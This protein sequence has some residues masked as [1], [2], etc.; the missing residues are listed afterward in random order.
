MKNNLKNEIRNF[1]LNWNNK[2]PID[3]WWR[4]KHNIPFGSKIH[5]DISF[6]EM[7][8]EY[9]EDF[10]MN[11]PQILEER[12]KVKETKENNE[13]FDNFNIDEYNE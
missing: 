5:K 10:I 1:I 4:K 6:L 7:F 3:L 8:I 11:E 13:E 9:E 12:K 2:Y